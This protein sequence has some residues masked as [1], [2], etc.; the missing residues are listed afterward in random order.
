MNDTLIKNYL[1]KIMPTQN[2]LFSSPIHFTI[3]LWVDPF[4]GQANS[5]NLGEFG[6]LAKLVCKNLKV[7]GMKK[8]AILCHPPMGRK[9]FI[10][11]FLT[12]VNEWKNEYEY[13]ANVYVW[14]IW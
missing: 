5:Q 4:E 6:G 8:W 11:F 12:I 9:F 2:Y 14:G 13:N 3:C 1:P 10:N 7:L